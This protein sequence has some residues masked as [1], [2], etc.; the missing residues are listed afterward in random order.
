[1]QPP[2]A[3]PLQPARPVD[4]ERAAPAE[5]DRPFGEK[6]RTD[7]LREE[8]DRIVAQISPQ[9]RR[10]L[11]DLLGDVLNILD[12]IDVICPK[13]YPPCRG[14]MRFERV[15]ALHAALT[16]QTPSPQSSGD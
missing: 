6:P 5:L 14:Y 7:P 12:N 15:R 2:H 4:A 10:R 11:A 13:F 16:D 3:H 9:A 8:A 1:M